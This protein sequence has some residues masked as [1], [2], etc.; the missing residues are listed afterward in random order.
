MPR[1]WSGR[2]TPCSLRAG[3]PRP[4]AAALEV[5]IE[6]QWPRVEECIRWLLLSPRQRCFSSSRWRS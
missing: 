4:N 6:A 5:S 1:R 3:G 2:S